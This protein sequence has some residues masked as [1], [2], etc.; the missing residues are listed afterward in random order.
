MIR[1]HRQHAMMFRIKTRRY[2]RC[3]GTVERRFACSRIRLRGPVY[4]D[5]QQ[6]PPRLKAALARSDR[7]NQ[8]LRAETARKLDPQVLALLE[9]VADAVVQVERA[10]ARRPQ[11]RR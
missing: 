6:L 5:R 3:A 4:L 7:H 1:D 10:L 11:R 8:S 2:R 9:V